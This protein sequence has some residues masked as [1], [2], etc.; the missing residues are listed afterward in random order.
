MERAVRGLVGGRYAWVAFTST[1][2]VKAI[3]EK[4]EE[5][6][7][8]ARAFSGVKIAAVGEQTAEALLDFG[9]RA[10]LVPGEHQSSE[11]LLAR[12][13]E[14][15]SDLDLLDRV[16]LPRADIATETLAAGIKARGWAI[17]DV[18]AYRTVRASPPPV[19]VREALRV[20][21][22]DAALFTSSSTVRNLVA[23]V[24]Q[25]HPNTVIACIGPATAAAARELGLRVDVM[26]ETASTDALV[27]ALVAFA[28][29]REEA[30]VVETA[31]PTKAA[32]AKAAK[33]AVRKK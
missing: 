32:P 10:D 23:L 5:V 20:G 7:L 11:G 15:D 4:L 6:G 33:A 2:A 31:K 16:L 8:D 27:D 21:R 18:T 13:P 26:A 9:L 19:S 17:D 1:N 28:K 25:P 22:V 12:W 30:E 29:A 3:R 14:H 24:G